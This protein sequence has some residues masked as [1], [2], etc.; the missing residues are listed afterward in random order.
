M[1]TTPE[2]IQAWQ[3]GAQIYLWG[4]SINGTTGTGSPLSI[5]FNDIM[6]NLKM[7]GM[8]VFAARHDKWTLIADIIYLNADQTGLGL[9][10][11]PGP[12][13]LDSLGMK[14]WIVQPVV[15]Y[16]VYETDVDRFEVLAGARYLSLETPLGFTGPGPIENL[17]PSDDA[18]NGIVG[19]RGT[20]DFTE[21]WMDNIA[22]HAKT[23]FSIIVYENWKNMR[24]IR[25]EM[26]KHW[27]VKNMLVWHLPNRHQG[28]SAKY[29][30]F[31]KHD[32]A[33]VLYVRKK[34][35]LHRL[36]GRVWLRF[37]Q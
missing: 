5:D 27:K 16:A 2:K 20:H 17:T 34:Y 25:G 32:I 11:G 24:V 1:V 13:T 28:F 9:P 35:F 6:D 29:R 26:E 8:G 22:T 10:A 31:S 37:L 21:K 3:F 15:S 33:L 23:D 19:V 7:A 36:R 12:V 18:W 30:F 14:A 4:A